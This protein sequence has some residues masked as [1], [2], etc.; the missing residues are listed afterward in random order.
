MSPQYFYASATWF[1][2]ALKEVIFFVAA[3][4]LQQKREGQRDL[5]SM[6]LLSERYCQSFVIIRW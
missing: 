1:L 2:F 5:L 3:K 4:V 6:L